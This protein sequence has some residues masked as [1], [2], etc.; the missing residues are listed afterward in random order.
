[1]TPLR[2]RTTRIALMLM[3]AAAVA[4]SGGVSAATAKKHAGAP[5]KLMAV[6]ESDGAER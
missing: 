5:L 4:G 3:I 2:R 1:M 6:Y